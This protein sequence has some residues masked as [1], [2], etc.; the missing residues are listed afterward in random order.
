MIKAAE[1]RKTARARLADAN[2]LLESRRYDAAVYICGYAVEIALKARACRTLHWPRFPET[3]GEFRK[4][5][6]RSFQTHNLEVLLHLSGR[7]QAVKLKA[8]ADWSTVLGAWDP[9]AR[10]KAVGAVDRQLAAD[11]ISSAGALIGILK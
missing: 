8:F 4:D 3:A 10:Y 2:A 1:L 5:G 11:V 7:E 6:L 9:E